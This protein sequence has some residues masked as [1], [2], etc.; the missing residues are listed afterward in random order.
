M[1]NNDKN[2]IF[3]RSRICEIHASVRIDAGNT[4]FDESTNQFFIIELGKRDT[5]DVRVYAAV[6]LRVRLYEA[7]EKFWKNK[8][9]NCAITVDVKDV[10]PEIR[11]SRAAA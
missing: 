8:N 6:V 3:H 11:T 7:Y 5:A 4:R 2:T 1:I 10:Q 9:T